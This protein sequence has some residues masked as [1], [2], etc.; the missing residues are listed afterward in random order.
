M[1]VLLTVSYDGTGYNGYQTQK[2]GNTIQQELEGALKSL[3]GK[4]IKTV[5]SGRTDA[6]VHAR[7]QTVHFDCDENIPAKSYYK[8]LNTL[9]P[10]Q[11]RVVKSK[12]VAGG[13]DARK[14]AKKK[15]YLYSLYQAETENP[16]KERFSVKLNEK[17]DAEKMQKTANLFI[18]E[19]DFKCF[20]ASKSGVKTTV[21]TIY[22]IRIVKSG[23]D[24]K[25][26]VTGNGFLYNMVRTL[27]GTILKAERGKLTESEI[28]TM[29]ETGER[30]LAGR[31]MPAK[32]L[33]LYK[34]I[35]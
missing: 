21:R 35:Y 22:E 23:R 11:I 3:T 7:A 16:L 31:T 13:F 28:K 15:T 20:C 27:V 24:I 19:H 1:R 10:P 34:V 17:V 26:Y 29:L 4:E 12:R 30:N 33:T 5:A 8:A 32:G 2:Q 14:S 9:L 18:G 6:G 25:V